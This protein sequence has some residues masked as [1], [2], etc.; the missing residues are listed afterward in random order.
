LHMIVIKSTIRSWQI[1]LN[2]S[3]RVPEDAQDTLSR[4][5]R[6]NT[7]ERIIYVCVLPHF[8]ETQPPTWSRPDWCRN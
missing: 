3:L 6:Y 4:T 7:R 5:K 8:V 2:K 1:F